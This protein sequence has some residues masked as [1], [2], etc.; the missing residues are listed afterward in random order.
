MKCLTRI[1]TNKN[2]YFPED[3]VLIRI[4]FLPTKVNEKKENLEGFERNLLPEIFKKRFLVSLDEKKT[5]IPTYYGLK[6]K[7]LNSQVKICRFNVA[8]LGKLVAN[9]S[10]IKEIRG[11]HFKN[12]IKSSNERL[13]VGSRQKSLECSQ[14]IEENELSNFWISVKLPSQEKLFPSYEGYM[15][16]IRYK[17]ILQVSVVLENGRIGE[18]EIMVPIVIRNPGSSL[19]KLFCSKEL[20]E[21]DWTLDKNSRDK[22]VFLQSKINDSGNYFMESVQSIIDASRKKKKGYYITHKKKKVCKLSINSTTHILGS[23]I[24]LLFNFGDFRK[25]LKENYCNRIKMILNCQETIGKSRI[26]IE[27]KEFKKMAKKEISKQNRIISK[28]TDSFKCKIEI[29]SSC[30]SQFQ[31]EMITMKWNIDFIFYFGKKKEKMMFSLPIDVY[32]SPVYEDITTK[33]NHLYDI[34]F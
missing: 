13:I 1:S 9:Q 21:M 26:A 17:I 15:M 18:K 6:K 30:T 10:W 23:T 5:N 4:S 27:E 22:Q 12:I 32:D 25:E 2:F 29:P 33:S 34:I 11:K 16:K 7:Q 20:E 3:E 24:D 19:H 14:I 8:F 28:F 31:S